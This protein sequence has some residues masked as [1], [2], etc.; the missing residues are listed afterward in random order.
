MVTRERD[1]LP[2]KTFRPKAM[3]IQ[4]YTF[5][6]KCQ[7]QGDPAH[8][9]D[10]TPGAEVREARIDSAY[11]LVGCRRLNWAHKTPRRGC[12]CVVMSSCRRAVVP[13]CQGPLMSRWHAR[14]SNGLRHF[15]AAT[16][17]FGMFREATCERVLCLWLPAV[18]GSW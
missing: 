10:I 12:G 4:K 14:T 9:L 15:R 3:C 5:T 8:V 6:T 17:L 13:S 1:K 18:T 7:C 2:P 16:R 11:C